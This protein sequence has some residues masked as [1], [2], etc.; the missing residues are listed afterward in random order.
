[1][2]LSPTVGLETVA[3][4]SGGALFRLARFDQLNEVYDEIA[5]ALRSQMLLTIR[6]D[7]AKDDNEWRPLTVEIS[8]RRLDVRAPAGYYAPH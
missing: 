7:V 3:K 8:D 1:M 6:T 4:G 2:V 5:A